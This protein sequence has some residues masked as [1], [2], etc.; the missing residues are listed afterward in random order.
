[1]IYFGSVWQSDT[2]MDAGREKVTPCIQLSKLNYT[3]HK[4]RK[5]NS[6][7]NEY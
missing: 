1:M 7:G 3:M 4:A 2:H 5:L 6:D